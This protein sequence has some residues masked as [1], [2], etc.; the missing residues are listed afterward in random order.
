MDAARHRENAMIFVGELLNNS[1]DSPRVADF[2][3]EKIQSPKG[4]EET[5]GTRIMHCAWGD[6]NILTHL[7]CNS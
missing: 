6:C 1:L 7:Y 4:F 3:V 2:C 5:Q